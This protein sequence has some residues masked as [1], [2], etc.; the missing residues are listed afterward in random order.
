MSHKRLQAY[1]ALG[2]FLLLALL[3]TYPLVLHLG[4]HVRDHGDPLLNAWILAWNNRQMVRLD[5]GGWF[6]ANIYHPYRNTLAY[7]EHLFPQALAALPVQLLS[8]NPILAY[9]VVLIFGF[10]T[11]AFGM[12]LLAR[13]LTGHFLGSVAAGFIF[14]FSPFMIAH[15]FHLQVITAGGIPL[16]FLFLINFFDQGRWKDLFLFSLFFVLQS[17]ANGY[18]AL[19]LSIMAG[20]FILIM[21][22]V[23]RKWRE[24]RFW[25]QMAVFALLAALCLGPFLYRYAQ[26]KSLL[27][28]QRGIG[29]ARFTSYLATSPLNVI[30]GRVTSKFHIPEGELFP[31]AV[32]V[33]LAA[34]GCAAS[35]RFRR[36][37]LP[38]TDEG[39][40]RAGV[41]VLFLGLASLIVFVAYVLYRVVLKGGFELILLPGLAIHARSPLKPLLVLAVLVLG[42]HAL[43]KT[44]RAGP[45]LGS[46][47]IDPVAWA[48]FLILV[49]AFFM[50]FGMGGPYELL[51][52]FI[53]GFEGLRAAAR[54]HIFVMFSLSI[55]AAFGL[56]EASRRLKGAA[57]TSVLALASLVILAE[58]LSVPVL[59]KSIPV[60]KD[61]PAVYQ[62][63]ASQKGDFALLELPLPARG[64]SP[65][66]LECPR[67]Y[68]SAYHWKRLVNGFSGYIPPLYDLLRE[69]WDGGAPMEQNILDL[70]SLG[71]RY[72]LLHESLMPAEAVPVYVAELSSRPDLAVLTGKFGSV[73]VYEIQNWQEGLG[74]LRQ[75]PPPRRKIDRRGWKV[76]ANVNEEAAVLA[77]DGDDSTRWD[78]AGNQQPGFLFEVDMG[79]AERL[80]MLRLLFSPSLN[81]YPRGFAVETTE[82]GRSWTTVA[83]N[84]R[85]FID[86][87]RYLNPH[88]LSLDIPLPGVTAR[89]FR[90]VNT[91]HD[92]AWYWSIHELD[93]FCAAPPEETTGTV[94]VGNPHD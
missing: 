83:R 48:L 35:L 5:V 41:R 6:E 17:L 91:G 7:S 33:L 82:D 84:D 51:A 79:R 14:A 50:T 88:D 89:A 67:I 94:S 58:Y 65:G 34:A 70:K 57:R 90:V 10:V 56:R 2:L 29:G 45:L 66:G 32:V 59:T 31:G 63:L 36:R 54:S 42:Y 69:R 62:W 25:S 61:I 81:D 13:R 49:L 77:V 75:P 72:L 30:Y 24:A 9:N 87:R 74:A 11:S 46:R 27:G 8:G 71:V 28:L 43:K 80:V 60:K 3:M 40:S 22:L 20:L 55:F 18:Y 64:R 4:T 52:M 15:L 85:V 47:S 44:L 86:I 93:A 37:D 76:S 78:T 19:Y 1:L 26:V 92:P 23:R 73:F 53:P 68:Y 12:F 16:V 21:T 38:R 39:A